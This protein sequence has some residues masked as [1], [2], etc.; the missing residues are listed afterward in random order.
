MAWS[1]LGPSGNASDVIGPDESDDRAVVLFDGTDGKHIQNSVSHM[2]SDGRLVL[3]SNTPSTIA[4]DF[5]IDLQTRRDWAFTLPALTGSERDQLDE[6][7]DSGGFSGRPQLFDQRS[8]FVSICAACDGSPRKIIKVPTDDAI[9][10]DGSS[11]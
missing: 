11:W 3:G 2:D 6:V 8:H 9:G 4:P 1:I 7:A 10:S 5:A